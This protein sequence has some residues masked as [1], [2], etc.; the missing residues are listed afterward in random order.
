MP[1]MDQNTLGLRPDPLGEL[2]R[3]PRSPSCNGG[4]LLR[5]TERREGMTERVQREE[6]GITPFPPKPMWVEYNSE[7]CTTRRGW[8]NVRSEAGFCQI[9][10]PQRTRSKQKQ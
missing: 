8:F 1:K 6:K 9:N 2:M 4:L 3:S 10:V 5:G 7:R